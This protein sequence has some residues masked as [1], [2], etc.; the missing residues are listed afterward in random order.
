MTIVDSDEQSTLY[1]IDGNSGSLLSSKS[2]VH[3]TA[4]S[5]PIGTITF[6]TFARRLDLSI[7][8]TA[9]SL[10]PSGWFS[11]NYSFHSPTRSGEI[12][13]WAREIVFGS[14]VLQDSRGEWIAKFDRSP[15][16]MGKVGTLELR[17]MQVTGSL[18]DE[19]VVTGIALVLLARRA[20]T[21]NTGVVVS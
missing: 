18:L 1:S 2:H 19:V 10:D 5:S 17:E 20:M 8:N 9:L 13:T 7:H 15:L 3:I 4:N 6:G 21:S 11:N 12:L 16:A 14:M